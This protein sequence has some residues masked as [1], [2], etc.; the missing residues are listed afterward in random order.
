MALLVA[1]GALILGL[2]V[3]AN[4]VLA[5][6][7]VPRDFGV[8]ALGTVLIVVGG[9]LTDGGLGAGLIRRAQPPSHA[10]LAAVNG[11]QLALTVVLVAIC[12]GVALLIGRDGFVIAVMTAALPIM[13]LKL[14]SS[15]VLERELRYRV[16]ATVDVVEAVAFYAWALTTVALGMGVWGF[17][18]GVVVRAIAGTSTMARLGPVGLMRPRWSFDRVRPLLRFGAQFQGNVMVAFARDQGLNVGIAAIAGIATLG[19]WN[20]AWRVLQM[21]LMVFATLGRI[22][23]PTMARLLGSGQDPR[24]VIERGTAAIAVVTGVVMVAV[25][26]FAPALPVLVGD[27]WDAVPAVI[28]WAGIATIAVHPLQLTSKGYLF[29]AGAGG[30]VIVSTALGAAVWLGVALPL[31]PELGAPAAGLGW[32]ASAVAQLAYLVPRTARESGAAI[33][34]H[35]A[36]PTVAGVA[37]AAAGWLAADAAGRSLGAG[38]LGLA[39]G[40]LLLLTALVL[41]ARGAVRDTRTVLGDA[42]GSMRRRR[43]AAATVPAPAPV[44]APSHSS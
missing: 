16:I 30:A 6:L 18:T 39:A 14:P 4:I 1:R 31:V 33:V 11:V 8:V 19:V 35:L 12:A 3:G 2:G 9:F 13:A 25:T 37:A 41:L 17:A 34:S 44:Q 23:Y 28:L 42:L 36:V 27:S 22:G 32:C 7:L 40:E 15:I 43:P 10:E 5:R 26:G 38:F 24:P 20:L 21:P 29:A